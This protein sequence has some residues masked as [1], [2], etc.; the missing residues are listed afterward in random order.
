MSTSTT[1]E[2]RVRQ[3]LQEV[4]KQLVLQELK[5][6]KSRRTLALPERRAWSAC[7]RTAHGSSRSG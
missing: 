4:G 3:Q 1:G 2:I 7:G 6:E 5:T